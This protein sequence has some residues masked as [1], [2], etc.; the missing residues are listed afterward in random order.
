MSEKPARVFRPVPVPGPARVWFAILLTVLVVPL[1]WLLFELLRVPTIR[2]DVDSSKVTISSS[3]GSSHE[4]KTI[5]L[6]RI[7]TA[8]SEL[9][10]DRSLRFGTEKPGYCVGFFAYP[11]LGEVFQIT[12]CSELGV[13]LISSG[14]ASPVVITPTDPDGFLKALSAG[15]PA[16]F[17]PPGKRTASW[18][19]TLATVFAILFVVALVLATVFFI[20]PARLSYA[21]GGGTLTIT[22]LFGRRTM[23]LA[24]TRAMP[25]RSLLG[26]RLSGVPLPGYQV[27]S[28]MLDSMATTVLAS[29]RGHD[30]V[31][32]EG[33]GR[34]FVNPH[35][36]EGFLAALAGEGATI[37]TDTTLQRRR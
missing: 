27:G 12:D 21:V 13:L 32:I 4:E 10:R 1:L 33:D 35:D 26:Q 6:A 25:H 14:E 9:L 19:L 18:W 17:E 23:P 5:S 37:I 8:R 16:T 29:E 11:R 2:Y 24:G 7:T 15:R 30:G 3:L 31:L 34:F 28:W 20:A 22:T 36:R